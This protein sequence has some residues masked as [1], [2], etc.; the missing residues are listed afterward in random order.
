[1]EDW[2]NEHWKIGRL[3][4]RNIIPLFH[5]SII[6]CFHFLLFHHSTFSQNLTPETRNQKPKIRHFFTGGNR[7]NRVALGMLEYW[8]GGM[9][10]K[11]RTRPASS[12]IFPPFHS[13]SVPFFHSPFSPFA[14]VRS[15]PRLF[16]TLCF[17]II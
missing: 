2:N 11:R 15:P 13:S 14:P 8:N 9:M 1:M 17:L 7:G 4:N 10:E 6:P 3:E 16:G 12:V 5:H